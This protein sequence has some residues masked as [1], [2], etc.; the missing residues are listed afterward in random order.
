MRVLFASIALATV[1][2]AGCATRPSCRI[3]DAVQL[4]IESSDRVNAD[5]RGRSLPTILRLY[6]LKDLSK[7]EQS[8]FEDI[9]QQD[10]AT[11]ADTLVGQEELTLYPGQIMVHR[12]QRNG[13]AD[14]LVGVAVF[15]EPVGGSW[16]TIQEWPLQGDPCAEQ[17]DEDAAPKMKKLRLR[18]FLENY[19][20]DSVNNYA[21]LPKRR[22]PSGGKCGGASAPDELPDARRNQRL[23]TFEEDPTEATPTMGE[24]QNEG[25]AP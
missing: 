18:M 7:I 4:E 8:A 12:F 14:F 25:D 5:E 22:C 11:L 6:Q 3:P 13:A 17:D 2:S 10:K 24:G 21:A 19:R 9:W 15:R 23:K 16:R 20:I 1:L